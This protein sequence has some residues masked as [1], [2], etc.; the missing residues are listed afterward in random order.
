M[1]TGTRPATQGRSIGAATAVQQV[2]LSQQKGGH[3]KPDLQIPY[4]G[5]TLVFCKSEDDARLLASEQ[6]GAIVFRSS[7]YDLDRMGVWDAYCDAFD[8]RNADT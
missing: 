6:A 3:L 4:R 1:S 7:I 2:A 5:G 8:A